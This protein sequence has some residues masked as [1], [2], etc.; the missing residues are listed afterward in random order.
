MAL[1]SLKRDD[2]DGA[3]EFHEN[4]FGYGT[5]IFL[6]GEQTE[7]MGL[8]RLAAGQSVTIKATGIV[9]RSTEQI[10]AD[11]DS[12]GKDISLAIQLTAIDVSPTGTANAARA[13][14][15]LYGDDED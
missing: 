12:G 10:E 8:K 4:V 13:A 15:V 9:T 5:E 14:A 11:K 2:D 7:K 6:D 3:Y 1:T